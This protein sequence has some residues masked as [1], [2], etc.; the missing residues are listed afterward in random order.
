MLKGIVQSVEGDQI[1]IA[2]S[3]GQTIRVPVSSVEGT[4]VSQGEIFLLPFLTG[5][6]VSARSQFARDLLNHLLKG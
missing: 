2:L 3:D 5:G 4:P 6:E 1:T